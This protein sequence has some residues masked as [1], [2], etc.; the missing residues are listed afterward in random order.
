MFGKTWKMPREQLNERL[1][2]NENK[3]SS[4]QL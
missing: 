2:D 4:D 3:S 1:S